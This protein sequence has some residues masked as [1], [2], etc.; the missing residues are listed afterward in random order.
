MLPSYYKKSYRLGQGSTE[1]YGKASVGYG[2]ERQG[3]QGEG[4]SDLMRF[5]RSARIDGGDMV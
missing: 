3:P 4:S 1:A 5:A 2:M